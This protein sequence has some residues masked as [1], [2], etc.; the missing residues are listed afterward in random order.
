MKVIFLKDVKGQGKKDE[1]KEVKDGYAMNFLIKNKL[2]VK[3]TST[4]NEILLTE[5]DNRKK[6][7]EQDIKEAT[8]LKNK[9]ENMVLKFKVKTGEKDKVFGSISAKQIKEELDN[10]KID[11]DKKKIMIDMPLSTLGYHFVKVELHKKV[12]AELKVELVK[13]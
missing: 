12:V 1:I 4:S 5:Q 3:Y 8:I 9:L 7:E 10:N 13:E 6:K 11:I 2:A